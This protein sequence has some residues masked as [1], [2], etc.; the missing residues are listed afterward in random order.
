[1]KYR[2]FEKS[3]DHFV[4]NISVYRIRNDALYCKVVIAAGNN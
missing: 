2:V 4:D 1:V 3:I